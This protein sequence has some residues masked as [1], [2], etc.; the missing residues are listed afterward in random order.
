MDA[1]RVCDVQQKSE[2][3]SE[4]RGGHA[5]RKRGDGVVARRSPWPFSDVVFL[6]LLA[7]LKVIS[8]IVIIGLVGT[9]RECFGP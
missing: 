8:L 3:I 5:N 6:A 7:L 4:R 9:A 1:D 2:T